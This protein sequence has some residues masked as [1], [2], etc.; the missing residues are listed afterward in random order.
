MEAAP[1][2]PLSEKMTPNS[3]LPD[4]PL[5][6]AQQPVSPNPAHDLSLPSPNAVERSKNTFYGRLTGVTMHSKPKF[7]AA[8]AYPALMCDTIFHNAKC[9]HFVLLLCS[10]LLHF[11]LLLCLQRQ[12]LSHTPKVYC[13]ILLGCVCCCYIAF[14]VAKFCYIVL[15]VVFASCYIVFVVDVFFLL[16]CLLSLCFFYYYCLYC[17]YILFYCL[18]RQLLS[19]TPKVIPPCMQYRPPVYNESESHIC[20]VFCRSLCYLSS[21]GVLCIFYVPAV[22]NFTRSCRLPLLYD[23]TGFWRSWIHCEKTRN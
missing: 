15:F 22:H 8:G 7:Y 9:Y 18:Q 11:V 4:A 13:C 20:L 17:C 14:I 1:P 12:L 19:H 3:S 6:Y 16:L 23:V 5:Q 2:S 21:N 10:L